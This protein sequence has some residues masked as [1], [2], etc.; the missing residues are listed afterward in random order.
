MNHLKA[1]NRKAAR[2]E[3]A[4]E[5]RRRGAAADRSAAPAAALS[6]RLLAGVLAGLGSGPHRRHRRAVPAGRARFVRLPHRL[7][8]AGPGARPAQSRARLDEQVRRRPEGLAQDRPRFSREASHANACCR[9]GTCSLAAARRWRR[10]T[11]RSDL[12]A[13]RRSR[14]PR[15]RAVSAG[16]GTLIIGSYPK[17][18][19]IID[20]A[21]EKVVGTI[22]FKSG[23]P[24]RTTHVARSQ[25]LLHH[26]SRDGEGRDPRHRVAQDDRHLHA[27]R[28]QQE[29]PH[30]QH[31]A[32]SAAPVR[33]DGHG[34]GDQADR[35][36]R[37]RRAD[38]RAVRPE[39]PQDR[40]HHSLAE[41]TRSAR[42]RTSC[43]RP[44][45]S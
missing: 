13:P 34:V 37:D 26:R 22:P 41:R 35:P 25:A 11:A 6:D 19:W 9:C 42:T 43:S 33:G 16:N 39:G 31:R 2:V 12:R 45:A 14:R 32:G 28:G 27:Q 30:P 1:V 20:E 15:S 24:R 44:T 21:T 23:I 7:L 38:A 36:L 29:G 18:F 5:P 8:L 4:T 10:R 40:P 17:Q 3:R